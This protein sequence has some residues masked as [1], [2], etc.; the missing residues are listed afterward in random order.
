MSVSCDKKETATDETGKDD[1]EQ[2]VD[3]GVTYTDVAFYKDDKELE[4]E[5]RWMNDNEENFSF[6]LV[7]TSE[8]ADRTPADNRIV[9]TVSDPEQLAVKSIK[10]GVIT[11]KSLKVIESAYSS[12]AKPVTV[13]ISVKGTDI[14][15]E[16]TL[17]IFAH[18]VSCEITPE[19][20]GTW[21]QVA[22]FH[23]YRGAYTYS[24]FDAKIT[25]SNGTVI[26]P[27][28]YPMYDGQITAT[29]T[30]SN[31]KDAS[32]VIEIAEGLKAVVKKVVNPGPQNKYTIKLSSPFWDKTKIFT[33]CCYDDGT[34][35]IVSIEKTPGGGV[36]SQCADGSTKDVEVGKKYK[37][38]F[39]IEPATAYQ[40]PYKVVI[41][42]LV[43][44][45]YVG[46]D[47]SLYTI[48]NTYQEC[49]FTINQKTSKKLL[50]QFVSYTATNKTV[51]LNVQ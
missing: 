10:D 22:D 27:H 44:S 47:E 11:L 34:K 17:S 49:S 6:S 38:K 50:I 35:S 13:T 5:Y 8:P 15:K 37:C 46:V 24:L 4:P 51:F 45:S 14:V 40:E 23:L 30:D 26:S 43:N 31:N 20:W 36:F 19:K 42:E 7:F 2:Y 32:D 21:K 41:M 16:M 48:V 25:Y 1:S 18:V 29:V 9:V 12:G 3:D 28:S 39:T 33:A